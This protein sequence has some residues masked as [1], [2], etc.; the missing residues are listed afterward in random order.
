MTDEPSPPCPTRPVRTRAGLRTEEEL[1]A[2]LAAGAPE[3]MEA[4]EAVHRRWRSTV[5]ARALRALGDTGEAED[6]AQQVFL[7]LWRGRAGYRPE[8]GPLGAW[9]AGIT[10][11]KTA[12]ALE[13]RARRAR[14]AHAVARCAGPAC[15]P[16]QEAEE[17]TDRVV[18]RQALAE[19]PDPQRTVL[20]L[21]FYADLTQAQIATSTGVPL[22][23]VK[24]HARRG[25]ARLRRALE[26]GPARPAGGRQGP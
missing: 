19:L 26:R 2:A 22:G 11:K 6:V 3:A 12:D 16:R 25:L 7:A 13:A 10:R 20:S 5:H 8:R 24:S 23:T 4:L 9:I 17:L 21:A 18:L 1:G 14:V 15:A